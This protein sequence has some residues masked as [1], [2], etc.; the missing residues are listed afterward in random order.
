[1]LTD[2]CVCAIFKTIGLKYPV[3]DE[4]AYNIIRDTKVFLLPVYFSL[5][6]IGKAS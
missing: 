5:T 6:N 4:S 3:I 1:M 2:D